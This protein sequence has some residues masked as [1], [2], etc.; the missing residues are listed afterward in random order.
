MKTSFSTK[1]AVGIFKI[2]AAGVS[3]SILTK[4]ASSRRKWEKRQ[5]TPS[6]RV[7]MQGW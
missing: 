5:A 7:K 4:S 2:L 3:L 6:M 1:V